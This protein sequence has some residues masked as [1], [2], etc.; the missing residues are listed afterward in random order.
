MKKLFIL[1]AIPLLLCSCKKRVEDFAFKGKVVD[2]LN[3]TMMT[4]N[5]SEYDIGYVVALE[6]PD[7]I[8]ADHTLKNGTTYHNCVILYRTRSR[9]HEGDPISGTM[10]LDNNYS[11]AYCNFHY[12]TGLPE[13]VCYSL[14]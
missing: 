10:Y 9:F 5:I 3:C 11:Q 12:Q 6:L 7:S 1:L 8:G 13:G 14:D 2:Y 4:T